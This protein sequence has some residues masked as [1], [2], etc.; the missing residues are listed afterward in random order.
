M[1]PPQRPCPL[2]PYHLPTP[3]HHLRFPGNRHVFSMSSPSS[4][5]STPNHSWVLHP[6]HYGFHLPP[7]PRSFPHCYPPTSPWLSQ[8]LPIPGPIASQASLRRC[9]PEI[10]ALRLFPDSSLHCHCAHPRPRHSYYLDPSTYP[11]FWM[12][13]PSTKTLPAADHH[14]PR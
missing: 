13:K 6:Y 4:T 12:A 11:I 5:A 8:H 10:A 14:Q 2:P 1:F 9:A 3:H 7:L